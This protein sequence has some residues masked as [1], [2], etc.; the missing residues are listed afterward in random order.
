MI[1]TLMLPN[2]VLIIPRFILFNR[3]GWNDTYYPFIVPALFGMYIFIFMEC[4][5]YAYVWGAIV[6]VLVNVKIE[7]LPLEEHPVSLG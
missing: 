1:S 3:L 6:R 4:I 2:T 7:F 5:L